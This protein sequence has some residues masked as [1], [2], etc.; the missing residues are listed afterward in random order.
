MNEP[1]ETGDSLSECGWRYLTYLTYLLNRH[2]ERHVLQPS[3][4]IEEEICLEKN[5]K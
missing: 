4:I 2:V 1:W 3:T 5:P